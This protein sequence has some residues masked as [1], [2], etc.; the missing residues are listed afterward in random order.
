MAQDVTDT[1]AADGKMKIEF[2]AIPGK[3]GSTDHA[4]CVDVAG[5][6]KALSLKNVTGPC[7][8]FHIMMARMTRQSDA[9]KPG[10]AA[11]W[12]TCWGQTLHT[13]TTTGAHAPIPG[14]TNGVL[15]SFTSR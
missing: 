6:S 15:R 11:K 4:I 10:I 13:D 5:L 14:L 2:H 3:P 12:C 9:D 7:W 1:I 8:A